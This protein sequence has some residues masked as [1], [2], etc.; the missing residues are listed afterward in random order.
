MCFGALYGLSTI[1]LYELLGLAGLPTFYDTLLQVPLLNLSVI[2]IDRAVRSTA[3]MRFDPGRLLPFL[4]GRRRHLAYI[5]VWAVVFSL[6]SAA[7]GVGDRH[8]GQWLPFWQQ[9]CLQDRAGACRYLGQMY[10]TYC[11]AGSEW[12]CRELDRLVPGGAIG[13]LA[14]A[15]ESTSAGAF[16]VKGQGSATPPLEDLPIVLRGSKGPI[17]DRRPASLRMRACAQGWL[18]SC[19]EPASSGVE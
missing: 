12:S 14:G 6:M 1:V 18:D 11:R 8:P 3:L 16:G 10:A 17:S 15:R 13:A 2:A 4:A 5:G 19:G 7:Q 9:A